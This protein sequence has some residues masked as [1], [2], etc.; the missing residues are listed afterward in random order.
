MAGGIHPPVDVILSWPTPNYVNPHTRGWELVIICIVLYALALF[1]VIARLWA[2]FMIQRNAGADDALILAAMVSMTVQIAAAL[3]LTV[4]EIP[5][6][7]M[8]IT[9]CL[10]MSIYLDPHDRTSNKIEQ[11]RNYMDS[12]VT[13]GTYRSKLSKRIAR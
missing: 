6:T 13:S 3:R 9:I 5:T 1:A 10:G 11:V 2:R 7:A 4:T 8:T 12:T